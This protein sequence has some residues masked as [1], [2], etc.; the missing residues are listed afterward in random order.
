MDETIQIFLRHVKALRE[1]GVLHVKCGDFEASI[2][3]MPLSAG[4]SAEEDSVIPD[5]GKDPVTFGYP[6]GTK[7][8]TLHDLKGAKSG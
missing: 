7:R 2:A 6:P 4:D 8:T 3:P 1:S 5:A